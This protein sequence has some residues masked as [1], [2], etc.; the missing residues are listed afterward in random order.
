MR[1][2]NDL[3]YTPR[4]GLAPFARRRLAL[5]GYCVP[6]MTRLPKRSG[7]T[8]ILV[9]NP[10][11]VIITNSLATVLLA[12][13]GDPLHRS[14]TLAL[15]GVEHDDALGGAAGDADAVDRTADQLAAIG[16]QHDLV[17]VLDRKR[18]DDA[19][20]FLGDRHGDDAFAAAIGGA[21]FIGRR[22]LAKTFFRDR[23]HELLGGGQ[24][25]VALLA[26]FDGARRLLGIAAVAVLLALPAGAATHR[27]GAFQIRRSLFGVGLD[28]TQDRLRDEFVAIGQIDAAHAHGGA[29][30]KHPHVVDR[31]ADALAGGARQQHVVVLRADLHV[32]NGVALVE[33]HGDDAG[34]AHIGKIRQL[35]A[36]HGATR[37]GEHHVERAPG[38]LVF[39]QR[40][41]G[42][43]GLALLQRQDVDQRLA[44]RLRRRL[45][46]PPDFFLVD[47]AARREEQE[48]RVG[49]GDE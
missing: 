35:V 41:D 7:R 22:P 40:H 6:E 26:E 3:K 12:L 19:A 2:R 31:E 16:D 38:R 29:A 36:A 47:L 24:L 32:D 30:G 20:V 48:R 39:R 10:R 33:L 25:D 42:G 46:Q 17:A 4:S 18:R 45:R 34:A 49:R 43:D 27:V 28:V 14:D 8:N 1:P 23:Q 44:A 13:F 5:R 9:V 37:G 15:G 11:T 21:V